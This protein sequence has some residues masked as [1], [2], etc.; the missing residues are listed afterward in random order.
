MIKRIIARLDIKGPNVVRGI[1]LEGLRVVGQPG[2]M[3]EA[4]G[5][6][7]IDEI[8][9]IDTVATLYGRNNTLSVVDATSRE[10]F[11]PLTVG[12]GIRT[13]QDVDDVLR[14]GADKVTLN[15]AAIRRPEFVTEIAR[16]FGSQCVVAAIEAKRVSPGKWT[17]LIENAREATGKDAVEWAK[18]V[19]DRGAGEILLTSIDKDGMKTGFDLDLTR[20][21]VEAVD[22][23]VIASGG[24][25]N[26]QHVCTL[27]RET[28]ADAVALGTL[29][30]FTLSDVATLKRELA[31]AGSPVRL[32]FSRE[33]LSA[34][35]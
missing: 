21:I 4:Y 19:C 15:S 28:D 13:L 11:I 22:I 33:L 23:P 24:A 2:P 3:A 8:A 20:A 6:A 5:R 34:P 18:Q 27:F 30:H 14:V 31:A 35:V 25:G 9:F 16:H 29:L 26:V 12:G 10:I 32:P 7:G 1:Q 17:V